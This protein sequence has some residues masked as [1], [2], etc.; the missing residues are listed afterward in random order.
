MCLA[1]IACN[2]HAQFGLIII[3][4][5][6]EYHDRATEPAQLWQD[7]PQVLAGRDLRAGAHG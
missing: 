3:A 4:N 5:R 7:Y 1:V 6:D 2:A